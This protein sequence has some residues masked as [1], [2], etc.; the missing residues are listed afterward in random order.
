MKQMHVLCLTV[1]P[2]SV[3]RG[4]NLYLQELGPPK[5]TDFGHCN[6]LRSVVHL[7]YDSVPPGAQCPDHRTAR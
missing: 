4:I 5:S 6:E 2:T 1:G 7:Q 3:E